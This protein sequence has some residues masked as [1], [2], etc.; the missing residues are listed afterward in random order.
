LKNCLSPALHPPSEPKRTLEHSHWGRNDVCVVYLTI[1]CTKRGSNSSQKK[2]GKNLNS[3]KKKKEKK[4]P[5][6]QRYPEVLWNSR[7]WLQN[8]LCEFCG[9]E[10]LVLPLT[11]FFFFFFWGT[12]ART[13]GL[14]LEPLHQPYF[15]EGFFKIGSHEL[16]AWAGFE[17]WSSWSL[18]S[19]SLG[20]QV[21]AT[22][23]WHLWAIVNSVSCNKADNHTN[24]S[25]HKDANR[26]YLLEIQLI[27]HL[28][29]LEEKL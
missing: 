29:L 6:S 1:N 25:C 17:P 2:M 9:G 12:G 19:E 23:P 27:L 7:H 26:F 16:F 13:S 22:R 24:D 15:C 28:V 11:F 10:C 5:S 4:N 3:N 21:W 20:S 18:S 14:H 8:I